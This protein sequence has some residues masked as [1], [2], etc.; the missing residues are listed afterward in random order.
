MIALV[1]R[2]DAMQFEERIESVELNDRKERKDPKLRTLIM[3]SVDK[4]E[5]AEQKEQ[6]DHMLQKQ[7]GQPWQQLQHGLAFLSAYP[8]HAV[9]S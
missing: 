5:H 2:T 6:S 1:E 7:Q 3:E 9:C 8:Q 4:N